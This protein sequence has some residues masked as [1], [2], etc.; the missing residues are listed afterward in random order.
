MILSEKL[1]MPPKPSRGSIPS[2]GRIVLKKRDY[3]KVKSMEDVGL[4]YWSLLAI[5]VFNN[6]LKQTK[7]QLRNLLFK[8]LSSVYV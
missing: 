3:K 5:F 2:E 7:Y 1:S 6:L 4:F 8:I